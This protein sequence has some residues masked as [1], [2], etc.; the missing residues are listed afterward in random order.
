MKYFK[1]N[2][3]LKKFYSYDITSD[4]VLNNFCSHNI[5]TP[6]TTAIR[7]LFVHTIYYML[8]GLKPSNDAIPAMFGDVLHIK[9]NV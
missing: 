9:Y 4:I 1:M 3:S 8:R 7:T 5:L 2:F 6:T